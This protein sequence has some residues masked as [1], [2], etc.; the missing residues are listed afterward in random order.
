[1]AIIKYFFTYAISTPCV[2]FFMWEKCKQISIYPGSKWVTQGLTGY[3][4]KTYWYC[5]SNENI[6]YFLVYWIYSIILW[7][8]WVVSGFRLKTSGFDSTCWQRA[9]TIILLSIPI[10]WYIQAQ[11]DATRWNLMVS[12]LSTLNPL[13]EKPS[14]YTKKHLFSYIIIIICGKKINCAI[15]TA[16]A[17][18][19]SDE[20]WPYP[21]PESFFY[22]YYFFSPRC[23]RL[24]RASFPT[25]PRLQRCAKYRL[26]RAHAAASLLSSTFPEARGD[27]SATASF[28]SQKMI[29]TPWA[30]G[31]LTTLI[32]ENNKT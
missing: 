13:S 6:I 15:L 19:S 28:V 14:K 12:F 32:N 17:H 2:Y 4:C 18:G 30:T 21:N 1:M 10:L 9:A 3:N 8:S 31:W 26:E 16:I 29:D 24:R 7:T 22:Y 25:R 5:L 20:L 27:F 11:H 23:F